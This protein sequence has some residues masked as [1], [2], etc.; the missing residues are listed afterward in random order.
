MPVAA[1]VAVSNTTASFAI[2]TMPTV[3]GASGRTADVP[4]ATTRQR[5]RALADEYRETPETHAE[6]PGKHATTTGRHGTAGTVAGG[7]NEQS[8]TRVAPSD[9][10]VLERR[11]QEHRP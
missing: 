1:L 7:I 11:Q 6:R 5:D 10:P 9:Q 4:G 2:A 8:G 3:F